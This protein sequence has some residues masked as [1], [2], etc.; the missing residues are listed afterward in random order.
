MK[1]ASFL[2]EFHVR[3]RLVERLRSLDERDELFIRFELRQ[4]RSQLL[5]RI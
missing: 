4:L 5:H 2:P 1:L 3:I